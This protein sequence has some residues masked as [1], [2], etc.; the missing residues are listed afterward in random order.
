ML[1]NVHRR[2]AGQYAGFGRER[3][4]ARQR[5]P[6]VCAPALTAA[7]TGVEAVFVLPPP[8]FDPQPG[9]PE[10]KRVIA[11]VG[12]ALESAKPDRWRPSL[13]GIG[14]NFLTRSAENGIRR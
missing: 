3:S 13:L 12:A 10:A 6:V 1:L 9:Y 5:R 14:W 4:L 11:A 2:R 8:E 7:F